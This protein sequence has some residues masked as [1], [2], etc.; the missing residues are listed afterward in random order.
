M[1]NY[2]HEQAYNNSRHYYKHKMV[3]LLIVTFKSKMYI[4]THT[5]WSIEEIKCFFALNS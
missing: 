4:H 2:N 5:V 3:A 1:K